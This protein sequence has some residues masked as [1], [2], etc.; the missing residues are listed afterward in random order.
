M[1]LR[2]FEPALSLQLPHQYQ[3]LRL[4]HHFWTNVCVFRFQRY[5]TV[6][7]SFCIRWLE[8]LL[9]R[10][11]AFTPLFQT[12]FVCSLYIS[13]ICIHFQKICE[14]MRHISKLILA[15]LANKKRWTTI[16][17]IPCYSWAWG[18]CIYFLSWP[19]RNCLWDMYL[20]R[21]ILSTIQVLVCFQNVF[22]L[23]R[24]NVTFAQIWRDWWQ[25]Y[26]K[27]KVIVSTMKGS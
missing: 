1:P 18:C 11:P 14:R 8:A 22:D 23:W 19:G 27:S 9:E 17:Q 5:M 15:E 2:E 21:W 24:N 10:S 7:P 3:W 26:R 16:G 12:K 6:L 20:V 13:K 25:A 4:I